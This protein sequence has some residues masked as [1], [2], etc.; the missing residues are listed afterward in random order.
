MASSAPLEAFLA[1]GYA[2]T[3]MS[4]VAAKVGGSKAT[5]YNYF[6]SKEE[7]FAAFMIDTCQ[8]GANATKA[9]LLWF[10]NPD[11]IPSP[12]C[13][14]RLRAAAAAHGREKPMLLP[15]VRPQCPGPLRSPGRSPGSSAAQSSPPASQS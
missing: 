1:E 4:S 6:K 13:V 3:S 7:L 10:L 11:C 2:E 9:P 12:G 8:I 5:L 14:E 15:R